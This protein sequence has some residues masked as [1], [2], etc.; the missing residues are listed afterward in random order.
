ML[1]GYGGDRYD[2]P[3]VVI[4]LT[5]GKSQD[6][7]V[8]CAVRLKARYVK[9]IV[10]G[11]GESAYEPQLNQMAS[12]P[13]EQNVF[14]FSKY[15][16]L[17]NSM[18]EITGAIKQACYKAA[19]WSEWSNWESC[20][21]T[22]GTGQTERKRRCHHAEMG[23]RSCPGKWND[24]QSCELDECESAGNGESSAGSG[25]GSEWSAWGDW[26]AWSAWAVKSLQCSA[27]C[28]GGTFIGAQINNTKINQ[29]NTHAC[30]SWTN[31][32]TW[33]TCSQ[34]CGRGTQYR[35]R[36]CH[37]H[38][39]N[40]S[41]ACDGTKEDLKECI[42]GGCPFWSQWALWSP[43]DGTCGTNVK[44]TRDRRCI[45]IK[46]GNCDGLDAGVEKCEVPLCPIWSRWTSWSDC[47]KECGYGSI[48]R[49]RKCI[50]GNPRS[51]CPGIS[52]EDKIC[53]LDDCA[54]WSNWSS[55][56][57]CSVTCGAGESTRTRTC[58]PG[59]GTCTGEDTKMAACRMPR[60]CDA[61]TVQPE[62]TVSFIETIPTDLIS[63]ELL[64]NPIKLKLASRQPT[65]STSCTL[66]N[67]LLSAT[68]LNDHCTLN[69]S[70]GHKLIGLSTLSCVYSPTEDTHIWN[71]TVPMCAPQCTE[72]T[73]VIFVVDEISSE[74][75]STY[76]RQ[77]IKKFLSLFVINDS[78]AQVG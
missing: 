38:M 45:N 77:F 64:E 6:D 52:L 33:S 47:S 30:P 18:A 60:A 39:N 10:I 48:S 4:I 9:I 68:C 31:W 25:S 67:P 14:Q 27:Q 22:C 28:G 56:G 73:D 15:K 7:P 44:R 65:N 54:M 24:Q 11:I 58:S 46:N 53:K 74:R 1:H 72:K 69:C 37:N 40:T 70:I 35:Q 21:V 55:L 50:N 75:Q 59:Y 76:V 29:C 51:D 34:S 78:Q 43:C 5:D 32:N 63:A 49:E 23:S 8:E 12:S 16:Q 19:G 3:D 66:S 36:A 57:G 17:H 71:D 20:S 13:T 42:I 61:T 62:T 26:G 2:V 41:D